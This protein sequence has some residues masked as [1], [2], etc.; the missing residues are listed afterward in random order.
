MKRLTQKLKAVD[1]TGRPQTIHVFQ[2]VIDTTDIRNGRS[3]ALGTLKEVFTADGRDL[4]PAGENTFQVVASG[5]KWRV[6]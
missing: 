2:A 1:E 6:I 5:E 4:S 3:E